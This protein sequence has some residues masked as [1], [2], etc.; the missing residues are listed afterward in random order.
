[1][2]ATSTHPLTLMLMDGTFLV[3][4]RKI[5]TKGKLDYM[6]GERYEENAGMNR[7]LNVHPHMTSITIFL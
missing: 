4:R 7:S 6:N 1:M 5:I 2:F 3:H